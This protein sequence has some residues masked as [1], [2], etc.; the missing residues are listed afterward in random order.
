MTDDSSRSSASNFTN[1]NLHLS[2]SQHHELLKHYRVWV[3]WILSTQMWAGKK[4]RYSRFRNPGGIWPPL[5]SLS[6]HAS[7]PYP[8]QPQS[9]Y[10][11]IRAD[12]WAV[13]L[14]MWLS[15]DSLGR[16]KKG[17]RREKSAGGDEKGEVTYLPKISIKII[18]PQFWF[19]VLHTAE[20][21]CGQ[22]WFS[23]AC[24]FIGL[25]FQFHSH[26]AVGFPPVATVGF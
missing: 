12:Q 5:T 20:S 7:L 2:S 6:K 10:Y 4:L 17:K 26:H 22:K 15:C 24:L 9:L 8:W 23:T 14:Y 25:I 11:L 18:N 3:S 1:T 19:L 13:T 21:C 16:Q